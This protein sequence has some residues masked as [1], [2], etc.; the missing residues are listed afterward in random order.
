L[1]RAVRLGGDWR[2]TE[3]AILKSNLIGIGGLRTHIGIVSDSPSRHFLCVLRPQLPPSWGRFFR[4]LKHRAG[5]RFY[6]WPALHQIG[7]CRGHLLEQI[8]R[9]PRGFVGDSGMGIQRDAQRLLGFAF[10]IELRL[11]KEF[12]KKSALMKARFFRKS[13]ALCVSQHKGANLAL[14]RSSH[15]GK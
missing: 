3:A 6:C 12:V 13:L 5:R 11:S 8:R 10:L 1:A 15:S 9:I 14:V 7:A 4:K 2:P